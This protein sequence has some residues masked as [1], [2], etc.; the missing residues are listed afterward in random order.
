M[1]RPCIRLAV[2][3]DVGADAMS[4]IATVWQ[5]ASPWFDPFVYSY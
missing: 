2:D 4:E 3:A 5:L 1:Q